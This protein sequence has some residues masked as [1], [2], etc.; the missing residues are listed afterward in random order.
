M[1]AAYRLHRPRPRARRL[2]AATALVWL[3]GVP[4]ADGQPRTQD[5]QE[6]TPV[7]A[8]PL[9][10][11]LRER[12]DGLMATPG[13]VGVAQGLCGAKPCIKVFVAKKTSES[14]KAIPASLEGY[15]V[16]VEETGEFRPFQPPRR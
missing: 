14:L 12:T 7:P 13:V 8:R 6:V 4:V 10:E 1:A 11:V 9:E 2:A 5:G 3:F 16:S 15:P